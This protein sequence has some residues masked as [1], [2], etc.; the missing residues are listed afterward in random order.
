MRWRHRLVL[1]DQRREKRKSKKAQQFGF[2][3][4]S[5][6]DKVETSPKEM[7]QRSQQIPSNAISDDPTIITRD[8][9]LTIENPDAE[10]NTKSSDKQTTAPPL[11]VTQFS[12]HSPILL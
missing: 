10:E 5:S 2:T 4:S 6:T 8:A 1:R 7:L 12:S 9:T 3:Q 11:Q